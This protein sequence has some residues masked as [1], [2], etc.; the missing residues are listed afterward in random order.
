MLYLN[1]SSPLEYKYSIEEHIPF[2]SRKVICM[3]A[4]YNRIPR[5]PLAMFLSVGLLLLMAGTASAHN[6]APTHAHLPAH[7]KVYKAIPAIGSTI[8]QT[9]TTGTLF[10]LMNIK[11]NPKVNKC[12]CY[13][14][15]GE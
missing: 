14:R 8:T 15:T 13:A 3:D 10:T 4:R 6:T 5:T 7:A 1:Y 11:P 9:P 12:L 2:F